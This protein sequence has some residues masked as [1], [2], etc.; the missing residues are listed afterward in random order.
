MVF[1]RWNAGSGMVEELKMQHFK[2]ILSIWKMHRNISFVFSCGFSSV[3]VFFFQFKMC[4][5]KS[6]HPN[7][8]VEIPH[9]ISQRHKEAVEWNDARFQRKINHVFNTII[10]TATNNNSINNNNNSRGEREKK[11]EKEHRVNNKLTPI[12]LNKH[13]PSMEKIFA[14][15]TKEM[16]DN[17]NKQCSL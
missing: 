15:P 12:S 9:Y 7:W 5:H 11:E 8:S 16:N 1:N 10:T 2:N 13:A 6:W 3:F 17:V 14:K 4:C